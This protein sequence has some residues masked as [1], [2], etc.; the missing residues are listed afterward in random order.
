MRKDGFT[1]IELMIVVVIIG[2]LAAIAIPMYAAVQNRAKE[3][4]VRGDT[5]TVQL[6]AED[7]AIQNGGMYA[8]N[9]DADQTD[10]GKTLQDLLPGALPLENAFTGLRSEPL[11]SGVAGTP[12]EIGYQPVV[13]AGGFVEG[14][15][16]T[17]HG[18][19]RLVITVTNGN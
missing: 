12:G 1:L 9:T 11:S 17:G 18:K 10:L 6:A 15:R 7:F 19:T 5:H 13:G 4:R 16:I 14:Y 2:I 3:A 8:T